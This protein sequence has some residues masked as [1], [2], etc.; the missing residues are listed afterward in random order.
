MKEVRALELDIVTY[1]NVLRTNIQSTQMREYITIGDENMRDFYS[2]WEER[3][4]V[5]E[6][7]AL[8]KIQDL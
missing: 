3:F 4:R 2:G 7:E 6:E 8:V 1:Q 5:N